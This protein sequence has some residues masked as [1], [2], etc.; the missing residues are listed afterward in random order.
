[1][2]FFYNLKDPLNQLPI[3]CSPLSLLNKA[4]SKLKKKKP[5]LNMI[6]CKSRHQTGASQVLL[7]P[8]YYTKLSEQ[9][10][11]LR[12]LIPQQLLN[13]SWCTVPLP[14]Q[15]QCPWFCLIDIREMQE[16]DGSDLRGPQDFLLAMLRQGALKQCRGEGDCISMFILIT[17]KFS[18]IIHRYLPCLGC[19][20][21]KNIIFPT[22]FMTTGKRNL[23][24]VVQK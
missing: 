23:L 4:S 3:T 21:E 10:F 18:F 15:L 9:D 2:G 5:W 19:L 11:T 17:A 22:I 1:M 12:K 24:N 20:I 8:H 14:S 7:W 16:T 6:C 13:N